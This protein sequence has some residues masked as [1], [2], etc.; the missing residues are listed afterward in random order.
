MY[1]FYRESGDK[2]ASVTRGFCEACACARVRTRVCVSD[3][4]R[5]VDV[6]ATGVEVHWGS[7]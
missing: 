1:N 7:V 5:C 4:T 2:A 3:C 6:C